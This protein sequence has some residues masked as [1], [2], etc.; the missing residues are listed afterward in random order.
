MRLPD[1]TS[2]PEPTSAPADDTPPLGQTLQ[3]GGRPAT[4]AGGKMSDLYSGWNDW[5]NKPNN[6]AALM[7][8][9]IAMLQPVGFGESGVSHFVNAVGAAGEAHRRVT[10]N[11]Q[12][13]T[14]ASTEAELK[15]SRA[16]AAT[17][18]ANAAEQR[19]YNAGE[20]QR[21]RQ[22]R[23]QTSATARALQAQAAA[24][25]KYDTYVGSVSK[26]NTDPLRDPKAP[27]EPT[28]PYNEWIRTPEGR[29]S[30]LPATG[31]PPADETGTS[32]PP[33]ATTSAPSVDP[34]RSWDTVSKDPRVVA[35]TPQVR[36]ALAGASP[37]K[38][39]AIKQKVIE[40]V[41]PH[42]DPSEMPKV[43]RHFGLP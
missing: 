38:I 7:Q 39:A 18:T 22:E 32:P 6:R 12:A 4:A 25:A 40:L 33:G 36:A 41:S 11:E 28:M 35:A 13:D 27:I 26:R 1:D 19:A 8:F 16:N 30:L 17:V 5:I 34:S 9:G 10:T 24:R 43:L 23:D 21:L 2:A 14:K 20:T 31:A 29:E 15:E 3:G 42:V 37:E